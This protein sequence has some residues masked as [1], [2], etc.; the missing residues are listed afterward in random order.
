[1]KTNYKRLKEKKWKVPVRAPLKPN[2]VI[3]PTTVYSRSKE[4]KRVEEGLE[5]YYED[6]ES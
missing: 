5:E 1:M 2:K 3:D 4:K 6:T